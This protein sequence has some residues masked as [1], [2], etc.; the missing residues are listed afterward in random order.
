MDLPSDFKALLAL[1]NASGVE[2]VIVGGYALAQHGAPRFTGDI[3]ILVKAD[4]ANA[5]NILAALDAFGFGS[6][7]LTSDD[8]NTPDQIL[9]FGFPPQ[10][11]D[12]MTSITGVTW[13]EVKSGSVTG[14][15]DDVPA[16]FIGRSQLIANKR[17]T[18]RAQDLADLEA[19]GED[20]E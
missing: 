3:D 16:L 9:Q 14:M 2:Y 20:A 7:G 12:L 15:Y 11:I 4:A 18:G 19:L 6:L 17:A 13:D 1:F 5:R 8:F 10:R